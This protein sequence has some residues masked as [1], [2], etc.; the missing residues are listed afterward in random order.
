MV[1]SPSWAADWLAASQEI[2]RISR[3]PK[4][5]YRTHKRTSP[6]PILMTDT[7]DKVIWAPDN[8][9]RCHPKH[10][11]HFADINKLY[12]VASF[13]TIIDTS[14]F[15]YRQVLFGRTTWHRF[16]LVRMCGRHKRELEADG[17][18]TIKCIFCKWWD[19]SVGIDTRYRLDGSGLELRRWAGFQTGPGAHPASCTVRT[20][21]VS[22]R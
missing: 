13:W 9:W 20:G 11:E 6:V 1:Q 3:N 4:I 10:V 7:V 16:A 12:I 21:A 5:H 19:S 2:P 8:R 22:Q 17:R 18:I 15:T 14:R